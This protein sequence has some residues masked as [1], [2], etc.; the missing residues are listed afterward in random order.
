[1]LSFGNDVGLIAGALSTPS[2]RYS[3]KH[4]IPYR[5]YERVRPGRSKTD[6]IDTCIP[7]SELATGLTLPQPF[8]FT[9]M[10][11]ERQLPVKEYHNRSNHGFLMILCN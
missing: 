2:A 3:L 1:V 10:K 8:L 9:K 6:L 11:N 4:G 5:N 7:A